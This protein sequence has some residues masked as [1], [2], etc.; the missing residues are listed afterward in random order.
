MRQGGTLAAACGLAVAAAPR[1]FAAEDNTIRLALIGCGR[2]GAGATVNALEAPGGPVKLTAMADLYQDRLEPSYRLLCEKHAAQVDVSPERRFVGFDA[3][4]HAIDSLRPGDVALLTGYAA[5]RPLQLEY[6]V[7]KG[8]HVFMEKS[9]ACDPPAARRII[10][11]G[12]AAKKKNL[13][14]ACGLMNRHSRNRQELIRRIRD[15]A[16]GEI[17]L[18][19]VCYAG[20][21]CMR[22][23]PRPPAERELDWQIRHFTSFFWV[24]GGGFAEPHIHLIDEICWIKDAWPI[25]AHGVASRSAASPYCDQNLDSYAVE[26]TFADGTKATDFNHCNETAT[27][28]HG[29]KCSAQ[30]SSNIADSTTPHLQ[31]P[32]HRARQRRLAGREGADHA[33][34][35]GV[36]R[37]AGR[38]PQRP[39]A[40]RGRSRCEV[41][42]GRHH[43]PRGGP[44]QK[45]RHLEASIGVQ[46][47]VV[48]ERRRHEPRH[49]A[50]GASRCPG[51]LSFAGFRRL[52]GN[53][54]EIACSHAPRGNEGIRMHKTFRILIAL[55][56]FGPGSFSVA[57]QPAKTLNNFVTELARLENIQSG[58]TVAFTNPREGWI[59]FAAR[60]RNVVA[61]AFAEPEKMSHDTIVFRR[62]EAGVSTEAMKYLPAGEYKIRL[63]LPAAGTVET[64]A[65]RAIPEI[66]YNAYRR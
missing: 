44:F 45:N 41:E 40:Q 58:R 30:F 34:A 53:L 29:T 1:V 56:S 55:W 61:A 43:G 35:N 49:A 8:V 59:L 25:A 60:S 16:L 2:R 62:D 4:R 10:A 64:L 38:H 14:I 15:G 47:P 36:E 27:Y 50:A 21:A 63:T 26:F 19:N 37:P 5:W 11:A 18:V 24:S 20:G 9:F 54:I 66:F 28:V 12:E 3:Y 32:S 17:I 23:P 33:L 42:S 7:Q 65:I 6:A 22:L 13:K 57:A 51:A 52:V 39:A 31:G 48:P 46:L